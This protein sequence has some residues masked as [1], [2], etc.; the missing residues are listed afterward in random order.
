MRNFKDIRKKSHKKLHAD[1]ATLHNNRNTRV[2]LPSLG[3]LPCFFWMLPV[4]HELLFEGGL[5][6]RI[7]V[8]EV[9]TILDVCV[10]K[11]AFQFKSMRVCAL[12]PAET[13]LITT[14]TNTIS[15]NDAGT[16]HGSLSMKNHFN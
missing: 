6:M 3:D 15:C 1:D 10:Y 14:E 4:V 11:R 2:H 9:Y 8:D 16:V 12:V 5:I 7:I 13:R